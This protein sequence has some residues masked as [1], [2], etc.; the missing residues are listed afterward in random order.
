MAKK[1]EL[2]LGLVAVIILAVLTAALS[3]VVLTPVF[4]IPLFIVFILVGIGLVRLDCN[5]RTSLIVLYFLSTVYNI[6]SLVYALGYPEYFRLEHAVR[7]LIAGVVVWYMLGPDV[8]KL[9]RR[10]AAARSR[11][12]EIVIYPA[13]RMLFLLANVSFVFMAL[14]VLFLLV[15]GIVESSHVTL[16]VSQIIGITPEL[17][18]LILLII[19]SYIGT[20]LIGLAFAYFVFRLLVP[21]PSVIINPE[22]IYHSAS[23]LKSGTVKW[24]DVEDVYVS[25]TMWNKILHIVAA[26]GRESQIPQIT[27]PIPVEELSR[28]ISG[29]RGKTRKARKT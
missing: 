19:T 11:K 21:R 12:K 9:F 17:S 27:L 16:R 29:Y 20:P 18:A 10:E 3:L 1:T 26:S 15:P 13:K 25:K 8:E 4:G 6:A 14:G 28:M 23:L 24:K 22:G 5:A 2:P 7:I